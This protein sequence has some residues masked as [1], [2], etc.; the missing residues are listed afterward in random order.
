MASL[1][2]DSNYESRIW[3]SGTILN[4]T[5]TLSGLVKEDEGCY[6]CRWKEFNVPDLFTGSENC[7]DIENPPDY[8][9]AKCI[10]ISF[11]IGVTI[12]ILLGLGIGCLIVFCIY[13]KKK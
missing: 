4:A 8:S 12:G 6:T 2:I 11:L 3:L 9:T 7:L 13:K 5:I 10:G 1:S